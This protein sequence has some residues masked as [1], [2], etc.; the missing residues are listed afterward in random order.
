MMFGF[1]TFL[2]VSSFFG[3][4]LSGLLSRA[5]L[6]Q[7]LAVLTS[8]LLGVVIGAVVSLAAPALALKYTGVIPQGEQGPEVEA[9]K[10][11]IIAGFFLGAIAYK[12]S[13]PAAR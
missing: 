1:A 11:G 6:P 5:R 13:K 10:L 7:W 12:L 2:T 3:R 8:S 4:A 9:A